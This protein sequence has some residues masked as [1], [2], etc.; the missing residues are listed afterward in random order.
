MNAYEIQI[1]DV[2]RDNRTLWG[3]ADTFQ[4][5][6]EGSDHARDHNGKSKVRIVKL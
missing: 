3:L 2:A 6:Q 5:A 4:E 1:W